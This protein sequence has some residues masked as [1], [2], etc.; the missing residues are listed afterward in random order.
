MK[1][2]SNDNLA[3][4]TNNNE[5]ELNTDSKATDKRHDNEFNKE[6]DKATVISVQEQQPQNSKIS[7]K[8]KKLG[9]KDVS[10]KQKGKFDRSLEVTENV[11]KSS[12][13]SIECNDKANKDRQKLLSLSSNE[14][15]KVDGNETL[16]N[17][18][19]ESENTFASQVGDRNAS[20]DKNISQLKKDIDS[21]T[22]EVNTKKSKVNASYISKFASNNK[23][24]SK[25]I[26]MEKPS[27][28]RDGRSQKKGHAFNPTSSYP[29]FNVKK[30]HREVKQ[31]S[32]SNNLRVSSLSP[33]SKL[34]SVEGNNNKLSTNI[35]NATEPQTP[36][37]SRDRYQGNSGKKSEF[38]PTD[39]L[40]STAG[41]S[42]NMNRHQGCC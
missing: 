40:V 31:K 42:G 32:N 26:S 24:N 25:S 28:D 22:E 6:F 29:S 34:Q 13:D 4:V 14:G 2:N 12:P 19:N 30:I 20:F 23:V 27:L 8:K 37:V 17:V 11:G 1:P 38:T 9:R 35:G 10:H 15:K 39:Y 5:K 18:S 21:P 36:S 41:N 16:Q 33:T 7:K 3:K